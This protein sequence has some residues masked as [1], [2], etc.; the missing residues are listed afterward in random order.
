VVSEYPNVFPEDLPGLPPDRE[1][2]FA[3]DLLPGISLIFKTP[4]Q[5]APT[6]MK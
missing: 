3:M 4:Y 1:V 5:M 6:E 2:E